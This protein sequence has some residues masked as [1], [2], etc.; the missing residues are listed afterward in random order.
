M[1]KE[2]EIMNLIKGD[3]TDSFDFDRLIN[4]NWELIEREFLQRGANVEWFYDKD[5]DNDHSKAFVMASKLGVPIFVPLGSFRISQ[6]I[7]LTNFFGFGEI[8]RGET[9]IEIP[10]S[11]NEVKINRDIEQLKGDTSSL[12]TMA[13][14][15]E[16]RLKLLMTQMLLLQNTGFRIPVLKRDPSTPQVG[17][18]W[19]IDEG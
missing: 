15:H 2:T 7:N 3:E 19:I 12:S 1:S 13:L 5:R 11:L 18:I 9:K 14:E 6:E 16:E 4:K 17:Q 10:T 8:Y